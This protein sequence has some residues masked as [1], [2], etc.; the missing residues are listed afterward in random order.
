MKYSIVGSGSMIHVYFSELPNISRLVKSI[1]SIKGVS[2]TTKTPVKNMLMV[3]REPYVTMR[4]IRI[5]IEYWLK[6]S[7]YEAEYVE[8]Y[9]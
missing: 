4:D 6:S 8:A 9:T 7:G 5:G 1:E 2:V 3:A